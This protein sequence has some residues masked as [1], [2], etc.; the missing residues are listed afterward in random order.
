MNRPLTERERAVLEA[1]LA[2]D[3]DGVDEL[4]RQVD[5]LRVV[6]TCDCG[7]PTIHFTTEPQDGVVSW[8]HWAEAPQV[9]I[10]LTRG[11]R[12]QGVE[13]VGTQEPP[14]SEMPDPATMVVS[15]DPSQE[16]GRRR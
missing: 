8:G 6:D 13:C 3:V 10:L 4:R 2:V 15:L 14:P 7:C 1:L 5:A 11:G 12:L 16:R 9:A